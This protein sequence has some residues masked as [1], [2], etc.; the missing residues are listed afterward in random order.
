METITCP[1]L[2]NL[3]T[4]E[5]CLNY[6][7]FPVFSVSSGVSFLWLSLAF[8]SKLWKFWITRLTRSRICP[9]KGFCLKG[10][11]EEVRARF[12]Y[13]PLKDRMWRAWLQGD[14]THTN[15]QVF[16]ECMFNFLRKEHSGLFCCCCFCLKENVWFL[17]FLKDKVDYV[18]LDK[19]VFKYK[20]LIFHFLETHSHLVIYSLFEV[21][22]YILFFF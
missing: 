22:V 3:R 18:F 20:P 14:N 17:D 10:Q 7:C 1:I 11:G 21:Q 6:F 9:L 5:L 4:T 16:P 12:I 13:G 8:S 19:Q 2:S 15:S